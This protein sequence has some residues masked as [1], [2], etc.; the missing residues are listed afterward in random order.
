MNYIE[1]ITDDNVNNALVR[2]LPNIDIDNINSFI[3]NIDCMSKVRREFYKKI[4]G[5]RYNILE[6]AYKRLKGD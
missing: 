2:V 6:K 4:I 5:F 3:D 1:S